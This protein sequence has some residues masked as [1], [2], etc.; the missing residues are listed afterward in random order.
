M[1]LVYA[2]ASFLGAALLFLVEPMLAKMLLPPFGGSPMVWNTCTLFFQTLLLGAYA[3]VHLSTAR[4]GRRR[5]PVAHLLLLLVPLAVLPVALP[6]DVAPAATTEPALWLLRDLFLAAGLPFA[7]VA[8]TGPL[9]QRWYAWLG[10]PGSDDP[11]FLYA[12][13][14]AGSIAGLL[15]YPLLVEPRTT[16]S[17]Q[18]L[19]WSYGYGAFLLLVAF[20]GLQLLLRKRSPAAANGGPGAEEPDEP[21]SWRRRLSWL[22]LAFLPAS[23]ML[24]VTTHIST[25]IAAFPLLWS[26]PL[27]IYLLT[28]VVA[29]SRRRRQPPRLA[30]LMSLAL[31]S[32][33]ILDAWR[34][35]GLPV[36]VQLCVHLCLLAAVGLAAHGRLAA[37]RPAPRR[38]TGFYLTVSVGGAL[39]G[40][41][42]GLLAPLVFD[43]PLEYPLALAAV[44]LL[45]AGRARDEKGR[46]GAF[47]RSYRGLGRL[48]PPV[49]LAAVVGASARWLLDTG[50]EEL[51]YGVLSVGLSIA[52]GLFFVRYPRLAT[53][54][55]MAGLA[56]LLARDTEPLHRERTYFGSYRVVANGGTHLLFH[57]TTTHGSQVRN[58][59]AAEEPTTYYTRRG[60]IGD[61][62]QTYAGTRTDRV[63][64]V[65]LGAGTLAAYGRP[66]QHMDFYEIDPAVVRIARDPS[67]FGYLQQTAG[68]VSIHEGDGRLQLA[69]SAER[70]YGLI[71]L[72]AFSSDAIPV[73]LLTREAFSVYRAKLAPGGLLAVHVSN[74]HLRLAP[75][76]AAQ[77]RDLGMVA[78]RRFDIAGRANSWSSEW[79]VLGARQADLAP[80][81]DHDEWHVLSPT[82]ARA[83]TD[84]Y[85][86]VVTA[87]RMW[88]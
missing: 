68:T 31:A 80:L 61:V 28:F 30:A 70:S 22:G 56:V 66:G 12:A 48:V 3:Y 26:V 44:P 85:S 27:T 37:D 78:A 10:G 16:L 71:V 55:M 43:R 41:L 62:F 81:L 65:G 18:A 73:H 87:L 84:D 57:G 8:T 82:G 19:W 76:V 24:G 47:A 2:V 17:E 49:L 1:V 34:L 58:G 60:P 67:L 79:V 88:R 21:V 45:L 77:A 13:S 83:W 9:L 23:L 42:N 39:G 32:V 54:A 40:L 46:W 75:V 15:G 4:L 14:N 51:A 59:S 20:C 52:V 11:Y 72:D 6:S 63:A 5:Q 69:G 29:F 33:A 50:R 53:V 7:L 36:W 38:L 64:V 74:R 86:S 25:D 35:V